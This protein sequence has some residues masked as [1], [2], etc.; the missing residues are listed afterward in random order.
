MLT[1]RKLV[2]LSLAFLLTLPAVTTRLYS[3]DE[4]EHFAWLRSI[5]FDR[6]VDFENEYRYFVDTGV[7]RDPGFHET[8]LEKV[9]ETGRRINYAPV[10][11]AVLWAPFYAAG[12]AAAFMTGAPPDGFSQPYIAAVAYGSAFYA[13]AGVVLSALAARRLLGRGLAAAVIIAIGTPLIFYAYVAPGFGHAGSAF[14]VSLFV[15]LWI[16]ARDRWS[17]ADALCLGLAGG[18][19]ALVREQDVL[20]T[21]GPA[22]D[23]LW[24]H[25]PGVVRQG[26]PKTKS[27]RLPIAAAFAG[28]AAFIVAASPQLAAYKALNGHFGQTETAARKMTWTSPHALGVVF[29]PEHGWLAWTPLVALALGGLVWLALK[30]PALSR[31]AWLCLLMVA[32]Q[33]YTSGVVE[34]WTVAG[35]FGQRRFIALTPLLTI[36]MA[37][38]LV[39]ARSLVARRVLWAAVAIGIWWNI[40]LMAQF[41]LHRMDRQRLTLAANARVTFLELP[42]ELPRIAWTYFTDRQTFYRRPRQ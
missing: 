4:I 26:D 41:G 27:P 5:V 31:P 21:I 42:L 30:R 7:T 12:H 1:R 37:A 17:M 25:R 39:A 38:C 32:A 36:G 13:F 24:F 10:G 34:S 40:G 19:M 2:L 35:S 11:A 15:L 16:R 28:A 14:C 6:D 33:I 8:F 9:N 23:F 22:I 3:S 18:L 29:S 20:L